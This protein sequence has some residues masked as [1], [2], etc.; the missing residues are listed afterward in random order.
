MRGELARAA[1]QAQTGQDRTGQ[2][3]PG[4]LRPGSTAAPIEPAALPRPDLRRMNVPLGPV[5]V[6]GASNFPL[7]FSTAGGDTAADSLELTPGATVDLPS[8]QVSAL[9]DAGS[10]SSPDTDGWTEPDEDI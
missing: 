3:R 9:D 10:A 4:Q 5:A 8:L 1:R 2:P 6:F 7:A